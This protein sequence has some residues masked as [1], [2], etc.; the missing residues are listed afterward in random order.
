[1]APS[2]PATLPPTRATRS[3]VRHTCTWLC[4]TMI[5]WWS[6][7]LT[8]T[9]WVSPH[10][11]VTERACTVC[12]ASPGVHGVL[13]TCHVQAAGLF[14]KV[15]CCRV[16]RGHIILGV[17]LS[18][19]SRKAFCQGG[20][21]QC[22]PWVDSFR[23]PAPSTSRLQTLPLLKRHRGR[24]VARAMQEQQLLARQMVLQQQAASA[25]AA[26]S[27]TQ[28]EVCPHALTP[29]SHTRTSG[30][31]SLRCLTGKSS[32]CIASGE[33]RGQG[34]APARFTACRKHRSSQL[35]RMT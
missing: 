26:A 11:S 9:R 25:V 23:N 19:P 3:R 35:T 5:V 1:M 21:L 27:K 12:G 8:H 34:G 18:C 17:Y 7:T 14:A 24:A 22:A 31:S 28:R 16:R 10:V 4:S 2:A 20:L 29:E 32:G 15:D 6:A 33:R 30:S 13:I